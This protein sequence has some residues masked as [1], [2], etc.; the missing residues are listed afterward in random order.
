MERVVNSD[1]MV[2]FFQNSRCHILV[3]GILFYCHESLT[4]HILHVMWLLCHDRQ[5][6]VKCFSRLPG[7]T[8]Y[9]RIA[10]EAQ[11]C[12]AYKAVIASPGVMNISLWSVSPHTAHDFGAG[13]PVITCVMLLAAVQQMLFLFP[14]KLHLIKLHCLAPSSSRI[15]FVLSDVFP[16]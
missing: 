8:H 6:S 1:Q 16:R 2:N 7:C 11:I 5:R 9:A 14:P 3:D 13:S 12:F 4:C 10:N 15:Q